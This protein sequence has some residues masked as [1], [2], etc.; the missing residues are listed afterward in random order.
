MRLIFDL[1]KSHG[2]DSKA[3]SSDEMSAHLD[4]FE[5]LS[6]L[7]AVLT[8]A[9]ARVTDERF[10][11]GSDAWTIALQFYA[12]LQ[13]RALADRT[14][15]E[16]IAPIEGFF[17]RRNNAVLAAKP[18][19]LQTRAKKKLAHAERLVVRAKHRASALE[20]AAATQVAP[21]P[22]QPPPMPPSPAPSPKVAPS[23]ATNG[24]GAPN[25]G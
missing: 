22:A 2:L 17:G 24:A 4:R 23:G 21:P 8:K 5:A 1:A 11:A 14:V 3:V 10:L 16:S 13:R 20:A 25:G 15:A 19:K 7:Q 6:S 12:L 9:T 18:T